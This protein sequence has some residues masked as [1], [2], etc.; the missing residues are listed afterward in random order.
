MNPTRNQ[1]LTAT[2][3]SQLVDDPNDQGAV[4]ALNLK[5]PT[6]GDYKITIEG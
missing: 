5:I 6:A 1:S 4:Y 3:N 2:T